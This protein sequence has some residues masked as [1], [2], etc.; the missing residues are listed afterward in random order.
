MTQLEWNDVDFLDFFEVEPTAVDDDVCFSY[1]IERHGLRL[2]FT[3]W[4]YESV[5]QISVFRCESDHEVFEL[6]FYVRKDARFI[7][8]K[9]GRYLEIADCV[10][11]PKTSWFIQG[12]DPFD[13]EQFPFGVTVWLS[14]NPEIKV[15]VVDFTPRT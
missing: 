9:R 13:A 12:A 6:L 7:K 10:I 14:I 8:D 5:I 2:L 4:Q 15:E 3:L 11:K 1:E